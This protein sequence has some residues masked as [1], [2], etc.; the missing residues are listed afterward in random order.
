MPGK[1]A[2]VARARN[3]SRVVEFFRAG[4]PDGL[5][6]TG[7][8]PLFAL[9]RRRLSDDELIAVAKRIC[10]A[11]PPILHHDIHAAISEFLREE[12]LAAD[13]DRV[14]RHLAEGGWM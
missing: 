7:H 9:L 1:E 8:S 4:Y 12:P 2:E 5:P 10:Q 13:A 14:S 6:R 11:G 3:V